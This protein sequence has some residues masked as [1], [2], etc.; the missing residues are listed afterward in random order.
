DVQASVA[1]TIAENNNPVGEEYNLEAIQDDLTG[2]AK[3]DTFKAT[4]DTLQTGDEVDG[5]GGND[6]LVVSIQGSNDFFAAP[7][8]TSIE[9][10]RV[11]APNFQGQYIELDLSN[12]DSYNTLESFQTTSY[13]G[14]GYASL[15]FYDIQNVNNT[16]IRIID[17]NLDHY[18]SYDTNAYLPGN[19]VDAVDLY[20]SE[21]DGS[22]IE[23]YNEG[24]N[25]WSN[26]DRV[27]LTSAQRVQTNTTTFNYVYALEV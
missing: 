16:D 24:T 22:Y 6:T 26:V 8:L 1:A 7:S 19:G 20:L 10:I 23:F 12:S 27:N 4:Q 25:D 15:W 18:F 3:A 13:W 21:V 9:T 11:N 2:T 17:T 14:Q 5:A